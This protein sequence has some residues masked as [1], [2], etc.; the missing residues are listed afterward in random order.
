MFLNLKKTIHKTTKPN[1]IP[2]KTLYMEFYVKVLIIKIILIILIT[3][4]SQNK[5]VKINKLLLYPLHY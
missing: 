2:P 3:L 4:I 5:L 1:K